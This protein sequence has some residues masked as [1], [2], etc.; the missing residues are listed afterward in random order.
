VA[1]LLG[2]PIAKSP[3]PPFAGDGQFGN[4]NSLVRRIESACGPVL[5]RALNTLEELVL[6]GTLRVTDHITCS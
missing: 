2:H 3:L 6:D 4:P 1:A 5:M